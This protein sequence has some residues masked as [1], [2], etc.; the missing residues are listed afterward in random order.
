[1]ETG[2]ADKIIDH[3][4]PCCL[5]EVNIPIKS[6]ALLTENEKNNCFSIRTRSDLNKI[7]KNWQIKKFESYISAEFS[8]MATHKFIT[9][10][11]T[12]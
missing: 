9:S 6:H 5:I 2:E 1:M 8:D 10:L 3:F 4:F 11:T 12:T 7:R